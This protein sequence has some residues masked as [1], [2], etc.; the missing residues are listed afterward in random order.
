MATFYEQP[1]YGFH[2]GR[3]SEF[4]DAWTKIFP[5]EITEADKLNGVQFRGAAM[6]VRMVKRG[7]QWFYEFGGNYGFGPGL[8]PDG[9][10]EWPLGTLP[11]AA[12]K[13]QCG[14]LTSAKPLAVRASEPSPGV[15]KD[16][17]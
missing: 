15:T 10:L 17:F 1:M 13:R 9:K 14:V 7:D 5:L 6:W 16:R 4:R 2:P 11:R 12:V 8:T 3:L